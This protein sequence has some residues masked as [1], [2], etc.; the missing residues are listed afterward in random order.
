MRREE[1]MKG[2]KKVINLEFD[3][4]QEVMNY[5]ENEKVSSIF[6]PDRYDLQS[7]SKTGF[8]VKFT[9]TKS[10]DEAKTLLKNGWEEGAKKLVGRMKTIKVDNRILKEIT[11]FDVVGFQC[12]VPRYLMG[13]PTNMVQK[14]KVQ[15]KEKIL[16]I[17][18]QISYHSGI[19]TDVM[20]EEGA[21][22]LKVIEILEAQGNRCELWIGFC[23]ENGSET[24]QN[25]V[26]IKLKGANEKLNVSKIAFPLYHPSMLRRIKFAIVERTE[27]L[28][29]FYGSYGH[30]IMDSRLFTAAIKGNSARFKDCFVIPNFIS[31]E[32]SLENLTDI[33]EICEV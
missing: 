23:N 12:S 30:P 28:V 19:T 6:K 3:S 10:L 9:K 21:K 4:L 13:I 1:K 16:K 20:L 32:K 11:K 5:I 26:L 15:K 31:E 14:K 8:A 33:R 18:K 17:V 29:G 27:G 24:I 22:A 7:E 25:S 2:K